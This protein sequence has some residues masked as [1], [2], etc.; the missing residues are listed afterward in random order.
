MSH[1]VVFEPTASRELHE[2]SDFYD[3][4]QPGLGSDFLDAV[5]AALSTV[6]ERPAAFPIHLG[7]TRKYV[8]DRFPYSILYWF[9]DVNVHVSAIAHHKRRP[10]YWDERR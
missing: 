6:A 4:E 10:G 9:D 3:L 2:A 5:E 7:Q 8:L 1:R